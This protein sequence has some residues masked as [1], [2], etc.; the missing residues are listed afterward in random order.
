[1]FFDGWGDLGRVLVVGTLA[2]IGLVVMLRVT[3]KRTLSKMNAFDLIVT[4]AL[5]S[6]LASTFLSSDVALVEGLFALALLCALQYA[7]TY[8]SLRSERF[9][10][11]VKATPTLLF[12]R[13]Q[14][15]HAALMTERIT[16]EEILAA[17]RGS[18]ISDPEGAA[19]VVL[20]TDGSLSVVPEAGGGTLG[21]LKTARGIEDA[22]AAL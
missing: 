7:V 20:E 9:K 3:G 8:T 5:G 17:L 1:M 19:A 4:V 16:Q 11:L 18:G 2:Y 15:I 6:T 12:Y 13:G 22:R 14:M 21:T 10:R